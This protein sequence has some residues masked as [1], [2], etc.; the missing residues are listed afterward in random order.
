M[1]IIS[2]VF[3]VAV[4]SLLGGSHLNAAEV[5]LLSSAAARPAMSVLGAQFEKI[6]GDKLSVRFELTPEVPKLIEAG[7]TADVAI[8]NPDHIDALIRSGKVVASSRTEVARFGLGVGVKSGAPKLD[9][10]SIDGFR[11]ALVSAKSVAYVGAGTSGVFF[12]DA[13]KR[14]GISEQMTGKLKPGSIADNISAVAKGDVEIVV[15]PV[16]LILAGSG[17]ELAGAVPTEYQDHIVLVAGL[18][19]SAPQSAGAQALIKH[20]ASPEAEA[21]LKDK[22]YERMRK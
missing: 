6:T 3:L 1:Q 15:M 22:G 5:K 18:T 21:V 9:V 17:I 11:K 7:E 4:I 12:V 14:L 10:S 19:T 20:L 8:A 2:K 16:P 13:L